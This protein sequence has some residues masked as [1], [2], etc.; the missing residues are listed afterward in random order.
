MRTLVSIRNICGATIAKKTYNFKKKKYNQ[1]DEK[2]NS[3][4]GIN[5]IVTV[6]LYDLINVKRSQHILLI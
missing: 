1:D 6:R 4:P 2:Q 3:N 5:S